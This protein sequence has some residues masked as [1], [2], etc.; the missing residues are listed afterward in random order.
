MH[1]QDH[2]NGI[3]TATSLDYTAN[4]G[5]PSLDPVKFQS[6]QFNDLNLRYHS[7]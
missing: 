7:I 5:I 3:T 1:D 6:Y 2:V 4:P